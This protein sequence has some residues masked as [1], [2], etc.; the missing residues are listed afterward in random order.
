MDSEPRGYVAQ[1]LGGWSLTVSAFDGETIVWL[2]NNT[3]DT[4]FYEIVLVGNILIDLTEHLGYVATAY[5]EG[6][7]MPPL[8]LFHP[9]RLDLPA[10]VWEPASG[11]FYRAGEG[12][13]ARAS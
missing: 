9:A 10:Y 2:M 1:L 11:R 8:V 6:I 5:H 13:H 4:G 12:G 7:E 3:L